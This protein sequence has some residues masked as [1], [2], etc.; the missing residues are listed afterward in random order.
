M[1]FCLPVSL[2]FG[3]FFTLVCDGFLFVWDVWLHVAVN[4]QGLH[5]FPHKI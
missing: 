3:V 5:Y 4:K 1:A 2:V